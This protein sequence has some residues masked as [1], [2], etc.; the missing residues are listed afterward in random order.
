MNKI[1]SSTLLITLIIALSPQ[2]LSQDLGNLDDDYL[3]SLPDEIKADVMKEIKSS[4][5][6]K[7]T[8]YTVRPS[9]KINNLEIGKLS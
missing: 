9:T 6:S 4:K 5:D 2:G 7:Q 3:N 8:K 1:K